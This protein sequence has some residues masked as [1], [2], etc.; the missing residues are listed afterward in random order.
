MKNTLK[1]LGFIAIAA[2]MGFSMLACDSGGD[3][4]DGPVPSELRG[5]WNDAGMMPGATLVITSTTFTVTLGADSITVG[6]LT[7]TAANNVEGNPYFSDA[8][9]FPSG[10]QYSGKLTAFTG[11][12]LGS[13]DVGDTFDDYIF[14][15]SGNTKIVGVENYWEK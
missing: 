12:G 4:E 3:D 8:D 15:N 14:L 1:F 5:T 9:E 7:F 2:I 6:D 10:Y 11:A 13:M